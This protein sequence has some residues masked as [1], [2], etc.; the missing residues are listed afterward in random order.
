MFSTSE[1]HHCPSFYEP[2]DGR[3][4][5]DNEPAT[6]T[7]QTF[8]ELFSDLML[9]DMS[10]VTLFSSIE[11]HPNAS[12]LRHIIVAGQ[13]YILALEDCGQ[14]DP[15]SA[16]NDTP[17]RDSERTTRQI[18]LQRYDGGLGREHW[19]YRLGVDGIVRRWDGGDLAAKSHEERE[20]GIEGPII[21]SNETA[22]EMGKIVLTAIQAIQDLPTNPNSN[23]TNPIENNRLEE[24]MG[25]NNQP[26]T[27]A[28]IR[29]LQDFL[30]T[31]TDVPRYV[32]TTLLVESHC[33][34]H[35]KTHNLPLL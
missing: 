21:A 6:K 30:A 22:E 12:L 35:S 16:E 15:S 26:I 13:T 8:N 3:Q 2:T 17:Y 20:L 25:L 32:S 19:S 29:G 27:L 14:K 31:A 1:I 34:Y 28:E 5:V 18:N 24:D 9:Q 33:T 11:G 10:E 7:A 4:P 23:F